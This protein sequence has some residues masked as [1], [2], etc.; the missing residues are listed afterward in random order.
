MALRDKIKNYDN[1]I[2]LYHNAI[3]IYCLLA[4]IV[5]AVLT[6]FGL[7][8]VKEMQSIEIIDNMCENQIIYHI[9]AYIVLFLCQYSVIKFSCPNAKLWQVLIYSL[10]LNGFKYLIYIVGMQKYLNV[11]LDIISLIIMVKLVLKGSLKKGFIIL[12]VFLVTQFLISFIRDYWY[13]DIVANHLSLY[14]ILNIDLFIVIYNIMKGGNQVCGNVSYSGDL[15]TSYMQSEVSSL[16]S[17]KHHI[18]WLKALFPMLRKPKLE[19]KKLAKQSKVQNNAHKFKLNPYDIFYIVLYILWNAFQMYLVYCLAK[20]ENKVF[21]ISLLC[22]AFI[23]NKSVFGLPLHLKGDIC[24]IVSMIFFYICSESLPF[25]A[26]TILMPILVGI[27]TALIS[28]MIKDIIDEEKK[29]KKETLREKI[30]NKTNNNLTYDNIYK[31]CLNKGYTKEKAKD[32]SDT[33]YNYLSH[34]QYETANIVHCDNR[35]VSRRINEF[36][37]D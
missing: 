24:F 35:T 32:I 1:R 6:L 23:V 37:K 16:E 18:T 29:I 14:F 7:H 20:S 31:I 12:G 36:L 28:S 27:S 4:L 33:V 26:F 3:V 11:P 8:F 13:N 17:S 5:L 2:R 22:I 9:L 25:S 19:E 30:K 10:I 34:S 15:Q 21:E